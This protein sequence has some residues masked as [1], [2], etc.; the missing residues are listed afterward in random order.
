VE[1]ANALISF[2][3]E[4]ALYATTTATIA[5]VKT[6]QKMGLIEDFD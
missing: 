4:M 2:T 5:T 6:L 1:E 3:E